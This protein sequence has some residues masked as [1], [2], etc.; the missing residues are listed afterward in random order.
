MGQPAGSSQS[1][2]RRVDLRCPVALDLAYAGVW[3]PVTR[4]VGRLAGGAEARKCST[5]NPALVDVAAIETAV[6]EVAD[7]E[8]QGNRGGGADDC[9]PCALMEP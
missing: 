3:R 7:A 6:D 9:W 8:Q 2:F 5:G 1:G 4:L